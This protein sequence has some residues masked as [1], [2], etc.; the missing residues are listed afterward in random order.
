MI[1]TGEEIVMDIS[2]QV[3]QFLGALSLATQRESV[4]I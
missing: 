3:P 1:M 2:I 4:V